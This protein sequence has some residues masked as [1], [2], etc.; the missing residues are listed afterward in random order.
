MADRREVELKQKI[1]ACGLDSQLLHLRHHCPSALV[2]CLL[3]YLANFALLSK[4]TLSEESPRHSHSLT[5]IVN[6]ASSVLLAHH[7]PLLLLH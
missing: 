2:I 3:V 7:V 5:H 1:L 6:M 4:P